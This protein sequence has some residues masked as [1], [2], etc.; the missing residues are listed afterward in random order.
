[1]KKINLKYVNMWDSFDVNNNPISVLLNKNFNINLVENNPDY[2][3]CSTFKNK[4][5]C[6][7]DYLNYKAIRILIS[8]ENFEP[9]YTFFDYT[10]STSYA[11]NMDRS[12]RI[13]LY[14]FSLYNTDYKNIDH[15]NIDMNILKRKNKF[16]NMVFSHD[17]DDL[18]RMK[19]MEFLSKYKKVDSAGKYLNNLDGNVIIDYSNK[20][21]FMFDY[22]FS[23]VLESTDQI[24][25]VTE[26]ITDAYQSYTIPIYCGDSMIDREL[27]K[28]SFID[29]RDFKDFNE[30]L[31][32]IIYLDNNDNEFLNIIKQPL[33]KDINYPKNKVDEFI[34][35][36]RMIFSQNISDA[37]RKPNGPHNG[38]VSQYENNLKIVNRLDKLKLFGIVK[39]ILLYNN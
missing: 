35:F 16:C 21:N 17:R 8:L 7:F 32:Y 9:D 31:Q 26:K 19:L 6:W 20:G 27:N 25:F 24:G 4:K 22:K 34:S 30:L 36:F 14:V 39:K 28:K 37:F 12:I 33:F 1:M 13:P 2:I 15:S 23:I 5:D 18:K 3:I 29:I 11:N 10:I 38:L